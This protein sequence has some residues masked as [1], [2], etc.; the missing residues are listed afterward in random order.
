MNRPPESDTYYKVYNVSEEVAVELQAVKLDKGQ[1]T[2]KVAVANPSRVPSKLKIGSPVVALVPL[3]ENEELVPIEETMTNLGRSDRTGDQLGEVVAR[4]E[5]KGE[6]KSHDHVRTDEEYLALI[7]KVKLGKYAND[8]G[9]RKKIDKLLW[10][11]RQLWASGPWDLGACTLPGSEHKIKLKDGAQPK[12]FPPYRCAL[13]E[14]KLI[15]EHLDELLERH[16]IR[17]SNS[18]WGSQMYLVEKKGSHDEKGKITK[19]IIINM[20][21][22]NSQAVPDGYRLPR[23]DDLV[24]SL[25]G[26]KVYSALDLNQFYY[27][28]RLDEESQDICAFSTP[29]G[30]FAPTYVVQGD[31]SAP[32]VAQRIITRILE[33]IPKTVVLIDDIA[34][35]T[36]TTEEMEK[37]LSE[38]FARLEKYNLK[39][40]P[41]KATLFADSIPFLGHRIKEG[42]LIQSDEKI[43]RV[44]KWP[45]PRTSKEIKGF[46]G[47][48]GFWRQFLKG[49]SHYAKPLI[50]LQNQVQGKIPD[51]EWLPAHQQAFEKLKELA[52]TAPVLHLFDTDGG[53]AHLY[54]DASEVALGALLAQDVWTEERDKWELHPVAYAS[55]LL[56]GAEK[57]YCISDLEGLAGVWAVKKFRPYLYGRQFDLHTDSQVVYNLFR[58]PLPDLGKRLGRFHAQLLGYDFRIFYI[59]GTK[60][61]ADPLS[62]LPVVKDKDTGEL[63]YLEE[64]L[65]LEKEAKQE[66]DIEEDE[67]DD[68]LIAAVLEEEQELKELHNQRMEEKTGDA[69]K[70]EE[71]ATAESTQAEEEEPEE[72]KNEEETKEENV[73]AVQTRAQKRKLGFD[74]IV[75]KQKEDTKIKEILVALRLKKEIELNKMTFFLK[76]GVLF[77]K[78]TKGRTRLVVPES[79]IRS[80]LLEKHS[81]PQTGHPGAAKLYDELSQQLYWPNMSERIGQFVRKCDTCQRGKATFQPVRTPLGELP[82][83]TSAF[84]VLAMDILGPYNQ[85]V[86][87][88]KYV[89]VVVDLFSRYGWAKAVKNQLTKTVAEFL[90]SDILKWGTPTHILSDNAPNLTSEVMDEV[91]DL[92]G[93][94]RLRS[95][96][97]FPSGNGAAERLCS[98]LG[99][100]IRLATQD[101]QGEWSKLLPQLVD[102]YN[103]TRHR[104]IREKPIV[105]AFGRE[106]VDRDPLVPVKRREYMGQGDYVKDL[107]ERRKKAEEL[108]KQ[109]L[110]LYYED[111]KEDHDQSKRTRP[112]EFK[113]GQ[114]VLVK[115][116][117]RNPGE[118][119]KLGPKYFGPAEILKVGDHTARIR[120]VANGFTRIRNVSHLRPYFWDTEDKDLPQKF[121]A[122]KKRNRRFDSEESPDGDLEQA[123]DSEELVVGISKTSPYAKELLGKEDEEESDADEDKTVTFDI[124]QDDRRLTDSKP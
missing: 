15:K 12:R 98:T 67:N 109:A 6:E 87:K 37:I 77:V 54:V 20:T 106:P 76:D 60:N 14:K 115:V 27:Q 94:K 2:C 49:M 50:D 86:D 66:E 44:K 118:S 8:P 7:A 21:Y 36:E 63:T 31:Q 35:G 119:R 52:V 19:R 69:P 84:Q 23:M 34:I 72:Y 33:G 13:A 75:E 58:K 38:V 17:P 108:A 102:R 61:C 124:P 43:E 46:L 82:R 24:D 113:V 73:G 18:P 96:P 42:K 74:D 30:L 95:S 120:F 90:V 121:T 116:M 51:S 112:H 65:V 48:L 29:F 81:L 41:S 100:M 26:T 47:F 57:N 117:H 10:D 92:M 111:M 64:E 103:N 89:V 22:P 101:T 83:P 39:L 62:R 99:T 40:K 110:A 4:V 45:R 1:T 28:L 16:R 91:Y 71:E 3:A 56:R 78:D 68:A 9:V 93:I 25:A 88:N 123:E 59:K 114:Y 70:P 122:P 105:V 32:P 11:Y 97:F 5:D 55:R 79:M 107:Q 85:K 53:R 80:I 104:A